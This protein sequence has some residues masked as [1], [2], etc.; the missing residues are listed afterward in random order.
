MDGPLGEHEGDNEHE[1]HVDEHEEHADG[2]VVYDD[3]GDGLDLRSSQ[4]D[5]FVDLEYMLHHLTVGLAPKW[6]DTPELAADLVQY[7]V[8][9]EVPTRR[10][11]ASIAIDLNS[12]LGHDYVP[13]PH[14][15]LVP[16]RWPT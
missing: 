13:R 3:E 8:T 9:S 7:I 4:D 2:A 1:E 10:S 15:H 6:E 5:L 12:I 14:P 16:P 11:P